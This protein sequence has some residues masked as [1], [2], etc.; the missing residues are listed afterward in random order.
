MYTHFCKLECIYVNVCLREA[1]E[2]Q[3]LYY[4]FASSHSHLSIPSLALLSFRFEL[5]V[6]Y[7]HARSS[8]LAEWGIP[9]VHNAHPALPHTSIAYGAISCLFWLPSDSL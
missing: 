1:G 3:L 2:A 5:L 8:L 4:I 6:Q 9:Q 7:K